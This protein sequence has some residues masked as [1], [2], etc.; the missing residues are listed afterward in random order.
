MMT[1]MLRLLEFFQVDKN[2]LKDVLEVM[3]RLGI[4]SLFAVISP[5]VGRLLP[6]LLK[7]I[8]KL[9]CRFMRTYD[10]SVYDRF[11]KPH[12]DSLVLIGTLT[13]V[14]IGV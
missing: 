10:E 9:F 2:I 4:F 13:F 1:A 6:R 8:F 14:A 3:L 5:F 11:I 12:H 7:G